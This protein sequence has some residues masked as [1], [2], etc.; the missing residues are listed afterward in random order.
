MDVPRRI[1][2]LEGQNAQGKTTIL[3]AIYF[4]ATFSSFQTQNDRQVINF[5]VDDQP[6]AVARI[7]ADFI[8]ADQPHR[9]EVRIIRET[10]GNGSARVRKEI[11]IDGNKRTIN[12]AL[13]M[14]NAVIFLPQMTRIFDGGPDERRRYLNLAISQTLPGYAEALNQYNQVRTQRNALLKLLSEKGGDPDQLIYWDTLLVEK[15]SKILKNRIDSIAEIEAEAVRIHQRL[16]N[17]KEILRM[18]YQP[19]YDPA[20]SSQEQYMLPLNDSKDRTSYTIEDIRK[21]FME[22]LASVRKEELQRGITVVGPHRDEL[23]FISNRIDLGTYGSRGQIRTALLALKMAEVAWL[24]SKTGHW[25]VQLL[26]EIL[27]ELDGQRR[28]D[29]MAYLVECEQTM[30]TTADLTSF[31]SELIDIGTI[32]HVESGFVTP[33]KA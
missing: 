3:E 4:L 8:K 31:E 6:L 22:K 15:G 26:D 14:F 30:L 13:G 11:L 9:I 27:A 2:M 12:Q 18:N 7:V 23:R 29:L 24:K 16:T 17:G 10:N 25:P 33:V 20:V 19:G 1:L 28:K 32:W 5:L 21:G